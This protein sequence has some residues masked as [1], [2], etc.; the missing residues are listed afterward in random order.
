MTII[1]LFSV[2]LFSRMPTNMGN[3]NDCFSASPKSVT[4]NCSSQ[5]ED[6]KQYLSGHF[7]SVAEQLKCL[8]ELD[9]HHVNIDN[10]TLFPAINSAV[11]TLENGD[12]AD[13]KIKILVVPQSDVI[14]IQSTQLTREDINLELLDRT[15]R[16]LQRTI[17]F[18]GST[19]VY[20]DT[21]KLYSGEYVV[22]ATRGNAMLTRKV[23]IEK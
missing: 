1:T 13:L 18:Q 14:A 5:K 23:N 11:N 22:K 8:G 16:T 19:I 9:D 21:E 3:Q 6:Y 20:F 2:T 17:L 4:S 7:I 10:V 15:G 12:S